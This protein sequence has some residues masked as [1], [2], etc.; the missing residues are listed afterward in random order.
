MGWLLGWVDSWDGMDLGVDSF[1]GR[2]GSWDG[3]ASS[4]DRLAPGMDA[5]CVCVCVFPVY[6]P[7]ARVGNYIQKKKC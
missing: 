5:V 2:A 4:K 7:C 3:L 6:M 1:L